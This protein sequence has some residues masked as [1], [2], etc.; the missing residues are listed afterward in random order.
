MADLSRRATPADRDPSALHRCS[1]QQGR[2]PR[3]SAAHTKNSASNNTALL[4][5][6]W[7]PYSKSTAIS[8]TINKKNIYRTPQHKTLFIDALQVYTPGRPN[9]KSLVSFC[10]RE[11]EITLLI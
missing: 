4:K 8:A 1:T 9:K 2:S 5:I 7:E 3:C 6:N 11:T 10:K